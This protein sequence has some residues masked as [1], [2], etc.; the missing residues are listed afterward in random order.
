MFLPKARKVTKPKSTPVRK[1]HLP[2]TTWVE[3]A[4]TKLKQKSAK[5]AIP[6][7][8]LT[9]QWLT[10]ARGDPRGNTT[11][12]HTFLRIPIA[13]FATNAKYNTNSVARRLTVSQT[14]CRSLL[15]SQI[16][17]PRITKSSTRN[18]RPERGTE[19]L[20]S[21]LIGSHIGFKATLKSRKPPKKQRETFND[22][23]AHRCSHSTSTQTVCLSLIVPWAT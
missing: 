13:T 11:Y 6:K 20:L 14:I 18:K 21:S 7:R 23:W 9:L 5:N 12:L 4:L 19:Y 10:H 16:Q 1:M 17:S 2:R 3:A 22:S 15:N 8:S